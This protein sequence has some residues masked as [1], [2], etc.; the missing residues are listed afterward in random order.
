MKNENISWFNLTLALIP[1]CFIVDF[2]VSDDNSRDA[3]V[4]MLVITSYSMPFFYRRTQTPTFVSLVA[5][6]VVSIVGA[7]VIL[8]NSMGWVILIVIVLAFVYPATTIT[9]PYGK[10]IYKKIDEEEKEIKGVQLIATPS[11]REINKSHVFDTFIF[12]VVGILFLLA[13]DHFI[14]RYEMIHESNA[15][16]KI[17]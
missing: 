9:T 7:F 10:D 3:T 4:F 13:K 12:I 6:Y 17:K 8:F 2:I 5:F 14:E 16:Q 15:I 1:L 11:Q